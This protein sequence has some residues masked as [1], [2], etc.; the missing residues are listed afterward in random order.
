MT[1]YN[2]WDLKIKI[3]Q[4]KDGSY[5]AEVV[6]LPWCFTMGETMKDLQNNLKEA[7]SSYM[8]SLEKDISEYKFTNNTMVNS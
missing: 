3:F 1:I 8:L 5:Y 6:N 4:E 2:V 7:V